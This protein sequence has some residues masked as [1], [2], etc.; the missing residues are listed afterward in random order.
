MNA[1]LY[2]IQSDLRCIQS[3]AKKHEVTFLSV[4]YMVLVDNVSGPILDS[5]NVTKVYLIFP[6]KMKAKIF[7]H[8]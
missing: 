1:L 4:T 2:S 5:V 8:C 3:G 7:D 6:V